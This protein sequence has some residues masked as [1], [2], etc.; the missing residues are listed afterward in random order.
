MAT[1]IRVREST[2]NIPAGRRIRDVS[3]TIQYLD[4]NENPFVLLSKA[5]SKRTAT[6]SKFE[7][8]E[9]ELPDKIG[10]INGAQT[11]V[12]TAIEVTAG[13]GARAFVGDLVQNLRTFEV[14]RVTAIATDTWTVVRGV[15][16]VVGTAMNNLD[17]WLIIG[18]A[19]AEGGTLGT[20]R[21]VQETIPFNYTQIFRQP[22]GTTGTEAASN[23]YGGKDKP[24]LMK[25][26]GVYHMMDLERAFLFGQRNIDTGSTANPIR[27]TGGAFYWVTTNV[28][29]AGGVLSEP[30]LETFCQTVFNATGSGMTRTLFAAGTVVSVIDQLAAGRLNMVPSDQTFGI[31]VKQFQTAHGVLNI[32]KHRL[33]VSGTSGS[34]YAGY[35]LAVDPKKLRYVPLQTRDTTHREDVGTPGDD[36][37]TDEYLTEAGFEWDNEKAHG[38][39]KNVTG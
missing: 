35:A 27:Y 1:N 11:N 19:N 31:A 3:D 14:F 21:S 16:T 26:N 10:T 30:E 12:D 8:L 13:Q 33:L 18:N 2:E 20:E 37:W 17:D 34:G 29:D 38:Y 22:F 36:G 24:R 5:A 7:W 9:K 6:N 32:I 15:G 25:E 28:Q 39:L 23:N 4:P